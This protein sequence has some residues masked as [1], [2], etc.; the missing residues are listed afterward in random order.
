[1]TRRFGR[2]YRY[3]LGAMRRSTRTKWPKPGYHSEGPGRR[4]ILQTEFASS[5]LTRPAT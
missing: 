3:R 1:L 2:S 5:P 4:R